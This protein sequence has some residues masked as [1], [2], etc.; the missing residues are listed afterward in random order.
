M[1]LLNS[2]I[3][4]LLRWS[5]FIHLIVQFNFKITIVNIKFIKHFNF[6]INDF[7]NNELECIDSFI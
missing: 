5:V 1:E 7:Q 6:K 4:T 2:G 3:L